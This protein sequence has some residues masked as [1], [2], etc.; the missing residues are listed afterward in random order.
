MASC[1]CMLADTRLLCARSCCACGIL[2]TQVA[3]DTPS[4]KFYRLLGL[5]PLLEASCHMCVCVGE[6]SLF[7]LSD[8]DRGYRGIRMRL[9]L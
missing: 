2:P 9:T 6:S 1:F 4:P 8:R 5:D 3:S 7:L